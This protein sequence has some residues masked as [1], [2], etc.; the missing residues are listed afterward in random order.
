MTPRYLV[1]DQQLRYA[2]H[3]AISYLDISPKNDNYIIESM[4]EVSDR[5]LE[6][7]APSKLDETEQT[8]NS[9]QDAGREIDTSKSPFIRLKSNK[10][11]EMIC[12][13]YRNG[14]SDKDQ[15]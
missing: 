11:V 2:I 3:S 8:E 6:L 12:D 7:L 14:L 4:G 13:A 9:K 10:L 5:V 1:T 15:S